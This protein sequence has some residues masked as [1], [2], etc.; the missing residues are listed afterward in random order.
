VRALA[1]AL[2]GLLIGPGLARAANDL[3]I[4]TGTGGTLYHVPVKSLVDLRYTSVVRQGYDL[5][6]G[7]AALATILKYYYGEDVGEKQLI[8]AMIATGDKDKIMREGFSMLELKRHSVSLG[9]DSEGYKVDDAANLRHLRVPALVLVNV[10][11]YAHF[12]VVRSVSDGEVHI[13]DPAFGNRKRPI[14]SFAEEWKDN[15]ILVVLS[16]DRPG[17]SAFSTQATVK[18]RSGAFR[19]LTDFGVRPITPGPGQF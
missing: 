3:P 10:R 17:D 13:A 11:G 2:A 7:A 6:C 1:L 8:D 19:T 15:I 14:E 12:V 16:K 9:Y 4:F 5:S 18:G